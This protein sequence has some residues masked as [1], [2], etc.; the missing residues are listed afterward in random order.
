MNPFNWNFV[1]LQ[2]Q[3]KNDDDDG[4][5]SFERLSN[6]TDDSTGAIESP[7]IKSLVFFWDNKQGVNHSNNYYSLWL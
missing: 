7:F 3:K 6:H 2:E 5:A 4:K 1:L